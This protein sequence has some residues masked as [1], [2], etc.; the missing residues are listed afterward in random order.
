MR[1]LFVSEDY[2]PKT[3]GV[4]VV[5]KYLAEGL[6]E[7]GF[8][9]SVLTTLPAECTKREEVVNGV[10]VFRYNIYRD[11]FQGIHGEKEDFRRFV[12]D[13]SFDAIVVE[14]GQ[15]ITTDCLTP[16]LPKIKSPLLLHAHGLSGLLLK[17]FTKKTDLYHTV[18]NT[19]SWLYMQWYYCQSFK[20]ALSYYKASISLTDCD[21]GYDYLKQHV[22]KN[23]VLG[24][25]ADDMFFD[26]E[27]NSLSKDL[28][29]QTEGKPFLVSIANYTVVKNQLQMLEQ[30]YRSESSKQYALVM[31]GSQ[32]NDYLKNLRIRYKEL[33]KQCGHRTVTFLTGIDRRALPAILDKAK[34]YLVSSTYEEYS[35][36]IIEAMARQVPFISTNVGNARMLPGG[37]TLNRIDD[38]A[39]EIDRLLG[40]ESLRL[41]YASAGKSYAHSHCRISNAVENMAKILEEVH[42][43]NSNLTA[44]V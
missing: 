23:F 33:E 6:S 44:S 41:K 3:S 21:S 18:G 16:I 13:N 42:V 40:D 22:K 4:P 2:F 29:L 43:Q 35:I 24:N 38:M 25:A 37:V 8:S 7:R 14:C 10:L 31:I 27:Q 39:E 15:A 12:T 32:E 9:V 1:I 5:V 34:L 28:D 11:I 20:K 17:P 19:Y 26:A 36:S 30:F